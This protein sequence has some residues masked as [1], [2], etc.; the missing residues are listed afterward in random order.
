MFWCMFACDITAF[1][2]DILQICTDGQV[3]HSVNVMRIRA[4]TCVLLQ[5]S[6]IW[7]QNPSKATSWGFNS[8]SRHQSKVRKYNKLRCFISVIPPCSFP[9]LEGWCMLGV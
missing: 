1:F 9:A 3:F 6:K 7:T 2:C 4:L 8:P 5:H